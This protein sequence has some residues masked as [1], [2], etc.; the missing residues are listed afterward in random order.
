[1][2]SRSS[3]L[4]AVGK[5]LTERAIRAEALESVLGRIWCPR[6]GV[7]CKNLG[8][9]PFLFTFSHASGKRRALEEGPW[10]LSRDLVVM[11]DFDGKKTVQ[12][13]SFFFIPIWIRVLKMPLGM[14]NA[15]YGKAIGDE[16]GDFLEMD[17]EEDG[18]AVG[19]FLRSRSDS[20]LES[21]SCGVLL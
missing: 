16:V 19:E 17:K 18:S 5:V 12:E 8:S 4:Q 9:N 1:M 6:G 3:D 2:G 14:M 15:C 10:M 21:R 13:M 11:V 7:E 20:T